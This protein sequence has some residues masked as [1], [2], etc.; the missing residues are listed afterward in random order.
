MSDQEE[1]ERILRRFGFGG[2]TTI[3]PSMRSNSN[4][5][6]ATFNNSAAGSGASQ[7]WEGLISA[8]TGGASSLV[9]NTFLSARGGSSVGR[10]LGNVLLSGATM[11]PLWKG[12]G[13]LFGLGR[14]ESEPTPLPKVSLPRRQQF[15]LGV[16]E[17]SLFQ[18]RQEAGGRLTPVRAAQQ[19]PSVVVQV[20]ALD[21][22]SFLDRSDLIA[23]AVKRALLESHGLADVVNEV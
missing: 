8:A 20:Q 11:A 9:P 3:G 22:Q 16:D 21:S 17:D 1:L 23:S 19:N 13:R 2:Q 4:S 10:T 6:S 7:L 14:G 5:A 18:T 15:E 12:I